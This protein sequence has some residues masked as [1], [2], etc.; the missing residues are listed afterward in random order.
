MATTATSTVF[1]HPALR[2]ALATAVANGTF[3]DTAYYLYSQR[4]RN[5]KIGKFRAVYANSG[6][7]ESAAS[8]FLNGESSSAI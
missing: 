4:L 3:S 2:V 6:I 7:M 8:Y 5:W 1:P